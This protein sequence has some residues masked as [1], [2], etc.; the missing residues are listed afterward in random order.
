MRPFLPF[1]MSEP[2]KNLKRPRGLLKSKKAGKV[3]D[4][5]PDAKRLKADGG[6]EV[7]ASDSTER[8]EVTADDWEDLKE[9]FENALEALESKRLFRQ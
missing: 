8:A 9:L 6:D 4:P 3:A 7:T 5:G 1:R 2:A